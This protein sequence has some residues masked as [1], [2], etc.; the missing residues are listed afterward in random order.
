MNKIKAAKNLRKKVLIQG[1]KLYTTELNEKDNVY[2]LVENEEPE[3]ELAACFEFQ[4]EG[5]ALEGADEGTDNCW[6]ARVGAGDRVLGHL[7]PA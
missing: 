1:S 7:V 2:I 6:T 4:M 3:D 5:Y